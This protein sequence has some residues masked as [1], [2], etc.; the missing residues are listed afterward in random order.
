[1]TTTYTPGSI[2]A[3]RDR[4]WVVLPSDLSD[5]I[6][7]RPLTGSES[8]ICGVFTLLVGL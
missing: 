5:I 3:C 1:M 6:R 4:T 2:V 7:L 8:E